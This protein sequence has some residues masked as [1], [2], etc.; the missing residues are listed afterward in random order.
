MATINRITSIRVRRADSS[1]RSETS[2]TRPSEMIPLIESTTSSGQ[3]STSS[4]SNLM[5]DTLKTTNERVYGER[6]RYVSGIEAG[7]QQGA[8]SDEDLQRERS[9]SAGQ[10]DGTPKQLP[11]AGIIRQSSNTTA[12]SPTRKV[13]TLIFRYRVSTIWLFL[14]GF[15]TSETTVR[16]LKNS[17][18]LPIVKKFNTI[19]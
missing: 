5:V 14:K 10:Q 19:A 17:K 11:S 7:S 15:R 2:G 4:P 1:A 16:F 13:S 3:P 8:K 12:R 18:K 6:R 9:H